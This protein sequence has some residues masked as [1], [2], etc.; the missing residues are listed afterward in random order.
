MIDEPSI[1]VFSSYTAQELRPHPVPKTV[2]VKHESART[3]KINQH[4]IHTQSLTGFP[5]FESP[6]RIIS[7]MISNVRSYNPIRP[8]EKLIQPTEENLLIL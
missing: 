4:N 1:V 8:L 7:S 6:P 2:S 5:K 3:L